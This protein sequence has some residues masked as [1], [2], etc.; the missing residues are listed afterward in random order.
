EDLDPDELGGL[1]GGEVGERHVVG[2]AR[3]VHQQGQ[4]LVRADPGHLVDALARGQVGRDG[5]DADLRVRRG[6]LVQPL[7]PAAHQDQVVAVRGEAFGEGSADAGGGT[8]DEC[9]SAH[10]HFLPSPAVA[11]GWCG[12]R[13]R[14]S[15]GSPRAPARPRSVTSPGSTPAARTAVSNSSMSSASTPDRW[16]TLSGVTIVFSRFRA[17][18][19]ALPSFSAP[20]RRSGSRPIRT[21]RP[22]MSAMAAWLSA[23]SVLLN[24]FAACP[25]PAP[26]R[27]TTWR[28]NEANTGS[29]RSRAVCGPPTRVVSRRSSAAGRPPL[30]GASRTSIPAGAQI[31]VSRTAVAGRPVPWFTSTAPGRRPS[32]PPSTSC[33]TSSSVLTHSPTMSHAAARSRMSSCPVWGTPRRPSRDVG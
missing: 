23:S 12:L 14:S 31:S 28:E 27:W 19:E 29:Q 21:A 26:P 15:P 30:T 4:R 5:P 16:S 3:V 1:V 25:A 13:K 33:R 7:L 11:A 18:L 22:T 32:S 24:S 20:T 2:D 6:E 8:G 10:D 9:E 17:A